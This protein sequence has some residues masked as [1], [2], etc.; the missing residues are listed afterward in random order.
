[1]SFIDTIGEERATGAADEM[2]ARLRQKGPIAN[3]AAVFSLKPSLLDGWM[4]LLAAVKA[5]QDPR[6]Y[7][8]A[9]LA[10]ARALSSSYCMLAHGN[11]LLN[12][13]ME[14]DVLREIADT[15]TADALTSTERAI[16]AYAAKVAADASSVTATD[17]DT[18]RRE[19]LSDAE[20]LDI[21][22]TAAARCF[23]SKLLDALGV[24]P[25]RSLRSLPEALRTAL[26]PGRPIES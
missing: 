10:A 11:V 2:Y 17:I 25:D 19:G 24:Q 6:R 4:A 18:L 14:P 8:L 3:W 22:A 15:G 13:G 9:T 16:L 1:M 12:D 20:I 5:G 7:E 23:F 21:A 26:T